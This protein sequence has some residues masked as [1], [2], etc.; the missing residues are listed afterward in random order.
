MLFRQYTSADNQLESYFRSKGCVTE[1]EIQDMKDNPSKVKKHTTMSI[2]CKYT[3]SLYNYIITLDMYYTYN[4]NTSKQVSVTRTVNKTYDTDEGHAI[5]FM[6]SPFDVY[7]T[8]LGST[9]KGYYSSD[10]LDITY[11]YTSTGGSSSKPAPEIGLFLTAQEVPHKQNASM[12]TLIDSS[13]IKYKTS[14]T[15]SGTSLY[16]YNNTGKKLQIYTNI[17]KSPRDFGSADNIFGIT[18]SEELVSSLMYDVT[19]NVYEAVETGEVTE[20]GAIVVTKGTKYVTFSGS[21]ED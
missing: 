15:S 6:M 16:K 14:M 11:K 20:T 12:V 8:S 18:E 19:I 5:Y 13:K 3:G 1:A 17:A 4:N 21:K 9:S 2:E 7:S 10:A